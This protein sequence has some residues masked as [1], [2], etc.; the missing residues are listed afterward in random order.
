ME[1]ADPSPIPKAVLERVSGMLVHVSPRKTTVLNLS[2]V[3][4]VSYTLHRCGS[5]ALDLSLNS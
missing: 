1:Q 3:E 5:C 2:K 4:M